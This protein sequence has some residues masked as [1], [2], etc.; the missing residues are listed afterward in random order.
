M[1][2]V[3]WV[4]GDLYPE[5]VPDLA[6]AALEAGCDTPAIRTLAGLDGGTRAEIEP[7]LLRA[8]EEVGETLP[9]IDE[10]RE[11]LVD[12]WARLIAD[13][14]VPPYR[15]AKELWNLSHH[16]WERP[17]WHRLS[18]FVGLASE[19]EDYPPGRNDFERRIVAAARKFLDTGGLRTGGTL[20]E[21]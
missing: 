13:G 21:D 12:R 7:L 9:S 5:R 8:L 10:A 19:W 11:F 3:E 14:S 20:T 18:L 2:A 16:W 17:E 4:A 15:G 1:V 6:V